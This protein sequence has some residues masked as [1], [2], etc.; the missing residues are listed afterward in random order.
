MKRRC[1]YEIGTDTHYCTFGCLKYAPGI[2]HTPRLL[3]RLL[4]DQSPTADAMDSTRLGLRVVLRG[5]PRIHYRHRDTP[6][7]ADLTGPERFL[8]TITPVGCSLCSSTGL[9]S[10]VMP[11]PT[12]IQEQC[13]QT[14]S[15]VVRT[16][17]PCSPSPPGGTLP[18]PHG[19]GGHP[20]RVWIGVRGVGRGYR[21][22]GVQAGGFRNRQ[23]RKA[24]CRLLAGPPSSARLGD[25]LSNG[26]AQGA[27]GILATMVVAQHVTG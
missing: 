23:R 2:L 7:Y 18:H 10:H 4:R 15:T 16:M 1:T 6:R 8:E 27:L 13:K 26:S 25:R 21:K 5:T 3:V 17:T 9:T 22:Q 20:R 14:A 12:F 11:K 19:I 24:P